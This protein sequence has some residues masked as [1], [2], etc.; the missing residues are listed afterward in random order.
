ML[1]FTVFDVEYYPNCTYDY[2]KI[3][4]EGKTLRT[5]CGNAAKQHDEAVTDKMILKSSGN[6]INFLF[7][8]DYSNEEKFKGFEVHY[9]SAGK[10]QLYV[11]EVNRSNNLF[12]YVTLKSK[13]W[14]K[15]AFAD[16]L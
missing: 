13:R 16:K 14:S 2:V 4:E 6:R 12:I 7:H 1:R 9:R 8:S 11:N 5:F 15:R 3:I 10:A